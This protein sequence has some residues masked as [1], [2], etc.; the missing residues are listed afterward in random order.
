MLQGLTQIF[1]KVKVEL[2]KNIDLGDKSNNQI[3]VE[4]KEMRSEHDAIKKSMVDSLSELE[5]IEKKYDD[6]NKELHKRLKG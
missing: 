4:M 6:Y 3:L 2:G 1:S 5:K